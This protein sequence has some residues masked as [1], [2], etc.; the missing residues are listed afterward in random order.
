VWSE[1]EGGAR[2]RVRRRY[3]GLATTFLRASEDIEADDKEGSIA[4]QPGLVVWRRGF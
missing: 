3:H 1:D 4:R 2:G